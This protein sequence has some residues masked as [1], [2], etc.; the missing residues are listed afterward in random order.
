MDLN[1]AG[2]T[3]IVT[4][5]GSNIGRALSLAFARERVNLAIAEI[6]EGQGQKVAAEAAALGAKAVVV[7]TDVTQW[8]DV[9]AMVGT[10]EE[11]FG[12]VDVLVNNVGWTRD[13][14]FMEKTREEWEKEIQ[15]NL[16]GMLNCT[17]AVLDGMVQRRAGAIVSMGSDAGR[18][19][20]FR[21]G[22]YGAC[23]AGVMALSKSIAREVGK[24]GIRLNVVCPG[25]TMP[26]ADDEIGERSMWNAQENR[27]W[28]TPEMRAR[29]AKAY[30]LRRV[31]APTDVTGAVLFLASDQASFIT[32]QT[33]SVSG[34]YTMM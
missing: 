5:G 30:P 29:I 16:W 7:R 9:R 23:K 26:E 14:L 21:E 28:M 32:G 17:R 12:R 34:G 4:G 18:M 24:Y 2:K 11:R 10:V 6:D 3:V 31:A 15:L 33:L 1:L 27:A 22:V 20:E 25:M 8:N 13:A 19:G